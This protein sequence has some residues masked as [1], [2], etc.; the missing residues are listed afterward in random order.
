VRESGPRPLAAEAGG[1]FTESFSES[2][3]DFVVSQTLGVTR[4]FGFLRRNGQ[5]REG[6]CRL[7]RPYIDRSALGDDAVFID[8]LF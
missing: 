2:L 3:V 8:L 4:V 1:G 5:S 6:L 7:P